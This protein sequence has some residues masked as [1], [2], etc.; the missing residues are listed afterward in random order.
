MTDGKGVSLKYT[1]YRD[2]ATK[3]CWIHYLLAAPVAGSTPPVY[4]VQLDYQLRQVLTGSRRAKNRFVARWLKEWDGP[5]QSMDIQWFF[6]KGYKPTWFGVE[7][8]NS[9][10]DFEP[11]EITA[12][13]CGTMGNTTNNTNTTLDKCTNDLKM[14][15]EWASN[16]HS[17]NNCQDKSVV[18]ATSLRLAS[19]VWQDADHGV[20]LKDVYSVSF[21]PGIVTQ[22]SRES[23]SAEES[24]M[25][26]L[27]L[28]LIL[29]FPCLGAIFWTQKAPKD[30]EIKI[31][32]SA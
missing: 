25:W 29:I 10:D 27:P 20:D 5:V 15:L 6:P 4:T 1:L 23:G 31:R 17:V 22:K 9:K 7:P 24:F 12:V 32:H 21:S 26:I 8:A 16:S 28:M 13:C 14:G 19:G 11:S 3:E 18:L 2:K 30:S